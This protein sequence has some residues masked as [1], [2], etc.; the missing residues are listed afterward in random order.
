MQPVDQKLLQLGDASGDSWSLPGNKCLDC[1]TMFHPPR[2]HCAK[3]TCSNLQDIDLA[4]SG[5]LISYTDV[6]QTHPDAFVE[7]VYRVG[8]IELENGPIIEAISTKD[9]D[10]GTLRIG[11]EVDLVLL[12]LGD[13]EEGGKIVTYAFKASNGKEA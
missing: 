3:C 2:L 4:K 9:V 12:T 13:N 7:P 5:H 8:L 1:G 6:Y 10:Q 11:Q